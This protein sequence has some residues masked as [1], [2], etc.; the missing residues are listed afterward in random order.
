MFLI[1]LLLPPIEPHGASADAAVAETRRELVEVFGGLT[2]YVRAPA[3]GVWT[4]PDGR[5]ERDAV[6]MVEV[7]APAFDRGWWRAYA[8]RL[9]ARF[10]EEAIH[11]RA[12]RVEVLDEEAT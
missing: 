8:A 10:A 5:R 6:V 3:E 7:V 11:V 2:A 4:A 12:L 9:Q 1:Q